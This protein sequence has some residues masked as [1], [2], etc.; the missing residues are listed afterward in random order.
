MFKYITDQI[1]AIRDA[2]DIT[3]TLTVIKDTDEFKQKPKVIQL[4][5]TILLNYAVTR[6]ELYK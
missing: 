5:C 1:R 3:S 2:P 6:L 4:L